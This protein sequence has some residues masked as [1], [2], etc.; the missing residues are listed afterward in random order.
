MDVAFIEDVFARF[1]KVAVRNMFGGQGIYAG[2]VM[3]ALVFDDALYIKVDDA[4]RA[5]LAALG[6]TPFV[7]TLKSKP[8]QP[9][10]M[11]Y[12]RLPDSA[13]DDGEE[14]AAWA[15]RALAIALAKKKA[16]PKKRRPGA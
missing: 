15:R 14:A 6:S 16:A 3:F 7:Y 13:L 1:G 2:D 4:M 5:D 9:R 10:D 11:G 12:W 8:S